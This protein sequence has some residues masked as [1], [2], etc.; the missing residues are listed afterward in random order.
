V[1]YAKKLSERLE[2]ILHKFGDE[3]GRSS[4][5]RSRPSSRRSQKGRKL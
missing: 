3:L 1:H 4:P 5:S 2:E